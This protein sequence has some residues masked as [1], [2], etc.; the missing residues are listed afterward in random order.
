MTQ[1]AESSRAP[2]ELPQRLLLATE[3]TGFD[4]GAHRVALAL[5][6]HWNRVLPVVVP[7]VSTAE[8]EASA[9]EQAAR[10][11]EAAHQ[12]LEP[13][14]AEA[15][16]AGVTLALD[17][18]R[19]TALED[20]V[21]AAAQEPPCDLLI[22]RRRGEPGWLARLRVGARV[23]RLVSRARCP[24]LVCPRDALRP[25]RGLRLVLDVGEGLLPASAPGLSPVPSPRVPA[26]LAVAASLS[27]PVT[28]VVVDEA[29][30]SRLPEP[31]LQGLAAALQELARTAGCRLTVETPRS[32]GTAPD[33]WTDA[34]EA[35]LLVVWRRSR[36][37][38][39]PSL[40]AVLGDARCAVWVE[41]PRPR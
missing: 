6:A 33:P 7:L 34:G 26:V 2:A 10:A 5:A 1:A 24:V 8:F 37:G 39:D 40:S 15:R 13:L 38:R 21:L 22:V 12:R 30:G 16:A 18:R 9:P 23:E 11:D 29:G 14:R 25:V 32:T 28:A 35:D 3:A 41:P 27:L 4:A 36:P 17:V 20:E 31:G 19:G